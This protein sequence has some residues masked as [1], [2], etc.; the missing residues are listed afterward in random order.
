MS[1]VLFYFFL[2]FFDF[3][4]LEKLKKRLW[5]NYIKINLELILRG[6]NSIG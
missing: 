1:I 3:K 4:Y 2:K 6:W 5:L